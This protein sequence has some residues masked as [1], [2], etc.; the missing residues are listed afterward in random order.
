M[1]LTALFFLSLFFLGLILAFVKHPIYGTY[2]YLLVLYMGPGEAWWSMSLPDLRW[3]LLSAFITLIACIFH[4]SPVSRPAWY[5]FR[6]IHWLILF[7]IWV[8]IQS[9]WALSMDYHLFLAS[10]FSK[11]VLLYVILYLSFTDLDKIRDFFFFH[12]AGCF[13]WGILAYQNPGYGRL[14]KIGF[15]DLSGSAFASMQ[16]STGL[17]FAGFAF[18]SLVSFKRWFAFLSLPFML[19]AIVLMATRGA[20][21]GLLG[22][23]LASLFFSP[24]SKRLII[25]GYGILGG[26]LLFYLS[27]DLFLE[28]MSTIPVGEQQEMEASAASRLDVA[29]ANLRMARDYPMG[30]GH[31]GNDVLSPIYMPAEILTSRDGESLR[32]AHNTIMAILV[33]HGLIGIGLIML[34]HWSIIRSVIRLRNSVFS[35]PEENKE[36]EVYIGAFGVSLVV[37]WANAQ[38]ANFIKAEVIIWIAAMLSALE[39]MVQGK[40]T[41]PTPPPRPIDD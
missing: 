8:W 31:R 36:L 12:I 34:F 9:F 2:S 41:P 6:S 21:I 37:Y 33:D 7:S 23:A 4:K 17:V 15:G 39:W 16:I 20:F 24:K 14:E 3:S 11:Y 13:Y 35:S 22:G 5:Q 10:L 1:S 32:S 25:I 28:R 30:V 29:A 40:T 26:I 38:F 19:N 18:L 27:N